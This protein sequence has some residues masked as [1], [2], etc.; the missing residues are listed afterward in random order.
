MASRLSRKASTSSSVRI[1]TPTRKIHTGHSSVRTQSHCDTRLERSVTLRPYARPR[2]TQQ[3]RHAK[4]D[5][6]MREA[7]GARR[8]RWGRAAA[9]QA[10]PGGVGYM[11]RT[12]LP[13]EVL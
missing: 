2:G 10:G 12:D 8:R 1:Q 3:K 13:M 7:E 6:G 5:Q 9:L 4:C 11:V